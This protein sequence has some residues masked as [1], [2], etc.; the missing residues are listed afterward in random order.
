MP[1]NS[2]IL[3]KLNNVS[4]SHD[5]IE[6]DPEPRFFDALSSPTE[7]KL[8]ADNKGSVSIL[9]PYK[10][11]PFLDTSL[12]P[13]VPAEPKDSYSGNAPLRLSRFE[14]PIDPNIEYFPMRAKED[15]NDIRYTQDYSPPEQVSEVEH[16]TKENKTEPVQDPV[17]RV[18]G[19]GT[20]TEPLHRSSRIAKNSKS[21]DVLVAK[22][23][24]K[25]ETIW[26]PSKI[27][28]GL[29]IASFIGL[30]L[31]PTTI[32]AEPSH[33]LLDLG[34]DG[35]F[36]DASVL[37]PLT[38]SQRIENLRAYHARLDVL[39]EAESPDMTKMDW[40]VA[41]IDKYVVKKRENGTTDLVF[42]VIWLNGDKSWVKMDDL[43]LHDPLLVLTYGLRH[44]ITRKPGWEWVESF[45]NNDDEL[46]RI[47]HAHRVSKDIVYKFGVRVPNSTQEALRLDSEK[48]EKLWLEAIETELKQI[49]E[50]ETFR[51]LRDDEPT[52][53]GYRRIPYHCVFDVKFDGR[54]KCRLVAGG[55]R[56]APPKE[57]IFSGV[58]SMEAVRLGFILARL[59]GL[60]VCAGDIVNA[61]LYGKTREKVYVIAGEEFGE[62][63]GKRMIID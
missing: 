4:D 56:T 8:P 37:Q 27:L 41:M 12:P 46:A 58:V 30:C 50:Y 38:T 55:H 24:N 49:N 53:P 17:P 10:N 23:S 15:Y 16:P 60:M 57:D 25:V 36:T 39:N 47:I 42:K 13:F 11:E 52:P 54:R 21:E 26:K 7:E 35:L 43:R 34:T 48:D 59:N 14:Q 61:F 19:I 28:K 63:Q 18:K 51:I 2:L 62:N 45:V 20:S 22:V 6:P 44:Q 31:V 40:D 9:N 1:P 5:E 32:I 33:G 3:E 29:A